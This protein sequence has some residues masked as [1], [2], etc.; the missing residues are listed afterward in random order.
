M[1]EWSAGNR[2]YFTAQGTFGVGKRSQK[3]G[4]QG[5]SMQ[6][7]FVLKAKFNGKNR[8]SLKKNRGK[9][10]E[11]LSGHLRNRRPPC[12]SRRWSQEVHENDYQHIKRRKAKQ[13]HRFREDT[14][15]RLAGE[16]PI[17]GVGKEKGNGKDRS[18]IQVMSTLASGNRSKG[19]S[20]SHSCGR[21]RDIRQKQRGS[22]KPRW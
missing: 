2:G 5:D 15:P 16:G 8:N 9:D 6:G 14:G 19:G 17:S 1:E 3:K 10:P 4:L 20:P 21:R 22:E 13:A 11:A 12:P 7:F 18:E